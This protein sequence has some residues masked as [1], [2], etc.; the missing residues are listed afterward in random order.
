MIR[1]ADAGAEQS[2]RAQ[3]I[4][5]SQTRRHTDNIMLHMQHKIVLPI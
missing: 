3:E 5:L 4:S 1:F 2:S